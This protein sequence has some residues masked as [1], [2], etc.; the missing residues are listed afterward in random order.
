[1]LYAL[2]APFSIAP[3][4]SHSTS[5]SPALNSILPLISDIIDA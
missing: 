2:C 5:L 4:A 3:F 1:M